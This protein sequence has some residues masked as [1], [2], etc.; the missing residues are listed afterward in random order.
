MQLKSGAEVT[1]SSHND[2]AEVVQ[3]WYTITCDINVV[4]TCDGSS[5]RTQF[6]M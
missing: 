4:Q 3:M 2:G 6:K 5:G 1:P